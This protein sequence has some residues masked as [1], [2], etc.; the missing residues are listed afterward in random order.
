MLNR[1]KAVIATTAIAL[2]LA[3]VPA[4]ADEGDETEF[5]ESNSPHALLIAEEFGTTEEEVNALHDQGLGFGQI[6][7]LQILAIVLET[8]IATLLAEAEVDP[9]TGELEFDFGELKK[10]LTEEQLALLETLPKNFGAI[11]S[12]YNRSKHGEFHG[13]P[14]HAGGGKPA[15]AGGGHDEEEDDEEGGEG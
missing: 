15:W 3:A 10:T 11:V 6:F 5:S 14:E 12:A 8:D 13:K 9:E 4:I 7:K 1:T 2:V